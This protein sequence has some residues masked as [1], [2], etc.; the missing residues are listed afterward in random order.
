MTRS[1]RRI[2]NKAKWGSSKD[3]GWIFSHRVRS[4]LASRLGMSRPE[5]DRVV[6]ALGPIIRDE[7][8]SGHP[9]GFPQ[10]PVVYVERRSGAKYSLRSGHVGEALGIPITRVHTSKAFREQARDRVV[11]LGTL[12]EQATAERSRLFGSTVV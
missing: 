3:W 8:V 7:L 9:V 10:A 6:D 12:N 2:L 11:N 4:R 1:E 5:V